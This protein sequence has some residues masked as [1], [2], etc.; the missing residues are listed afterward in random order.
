MDVL[1]GKNLDLKN[2]LSARR[3]ATK[4]LVNLVVTKREHKLSVLAQLAGEI[5][6]VQN[7]KADPVIAGYIKTL[8]RGTSYVQDYARDHDP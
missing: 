8:I 2:D 3:T 5:Q 6:E 7:D 4:G 1:K